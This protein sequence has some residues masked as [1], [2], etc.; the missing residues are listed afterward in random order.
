MSL[1]YTI[2]IPPATTNWKGVYWFHLVRLWTE[3]C[4]LCIFNNTRRIHFIFTHRIK[5]L[6]KEFWRIL[7]ICNFDF[8]FFWLG[9]QYDLIH[10]VW[11]IM[12]R[13]GYPQNADVLVV[14]VGSENGFSLVGCQAIMWNNAGLIEPLPFRKNFNNILIQIERFPIFYKKV[15]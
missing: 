14:V 5:Q 2:I 10:V 15:I 13:R 7:K 9:I 11:V 4:P 12:R 3:S 6:Q 1:K 8:V